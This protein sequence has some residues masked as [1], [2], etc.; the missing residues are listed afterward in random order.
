[1]EKN[2]KVL[3]AYKTGLRK[4]AEIC[5]HSVFKF[6]CYQPDIIRSETANNDWRPL[7]QRMQKIKGDH[8]FQ[9]KD[10]NVQEFA[11]SW[12]DENP[13]RSFYLSAAGEPLEAMWVILLSDDA[14]LIKSMRTIGK[15]LI[16]QYDY[17]NLAFSTAHILAEGIFYTGV[18]KN[19]YRYS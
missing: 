13:I 18:L 15:R 6:Q 5:K 7:F 16:M 11:K 14:P 1:M 17:E 2:K 10:A 3:Q 4:T 9:N 8:S 12:Y 19:L